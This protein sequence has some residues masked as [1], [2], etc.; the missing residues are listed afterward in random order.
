MEHE[1]HEHKT[2]M[3]IHKRQKKTKMNLQNHIRKEKL[4]SLRLLVQKIKP[5]V[6]NKEVVY[7]PSSSKSSYLY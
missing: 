3:F 1:K 4:P 2:Y 7:L 5:K 6:T